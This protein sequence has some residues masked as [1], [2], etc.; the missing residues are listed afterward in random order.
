MDG[1]PTKMKD[2]RAIYR[3]DGPYH[4][5]AR[6]FRSWFLQDNYNAIAAEC[7]EHDRV[8]DLAC[9]EG[10]LGRHLNVA[11]LAGVDYS[12][13]ALRLNRELHPRTYDQLLL[14][15]LR[16]LDTVG[17]EL[18]SFSIV[19]C[20]LSLMYLFADEL[21]KCLRDVHGLLSS[22]GSFVCTYPTVGPHR[23]GSIE[24]AELRPD[25]LN[26][27]LRGAGFTSKHVTP[28]CSFVSQDVVERST[29]PG[30]EAVAHQAYLD[31]KRE[32]FMETSYHF[33]WAGVRD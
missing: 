10:C 26:Q 2:F 17:F 13:D 33:L 5:T 19:V 24:A 20:S 8:L 15:D 21:A 9:G 11:W 12:A 23:A 18:G 22:G 14:G 27:Q 30:T 16:S 4:H 1:N 25:E 31:A 32:M 28:I 7:R 29:V 3:T 6:G